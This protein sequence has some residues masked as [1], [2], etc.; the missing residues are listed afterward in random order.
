MAVYTINPI[1]DKRWYRFISEN[2][3]ATIF[4][5]PA[6][7]TVLKKQYG[8]S[9][10][11]LAVI[12]GNDEI[13]AGIPFCAVS[14]LFK[15]KWISLPFSDYSLPLF[16][17][18]EQL[19]EISVFLINEHQKGKVD[20]IEVY[21]E[22]NQSNGFAKDSSYVYHITE[23]NKDEK[24]LFNSFHR[25]KCQGISKSIKQNLNTRFSLEPEA[26]EIFY[27]LHLK[28]RKKLGIPIQPK[29]FFFHIYEHILKND[30]GFI[31]VVTKDNINLAAGLFMGFND[32][33]TYKY[34][35]SDPD[36]LQ[37][38]PNNLIIWSAMC[39]GMKKGFKFFDFGKSDLANEGLRSFKDGWSAVERPLYYSYLP[40]LPSSNNSFDFIKDKLVA[41]VIKSSPGI[42]CRLIGE[43]AYKYFPSI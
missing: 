32:T 36:H 13:T 8:F 18:E 17:H 35:A 43:V 7:L 21:W 28:T 20:S 38:R 41:P 26:V 39:E 12:N 5:H 1:E 37:Y 2:P 23:L 3:K 15:K 19:N 24:G 29:S 16:C 42:V 33:L 22:I 30:L 27:D 25:T 9:V 34:N 40:A 31:V 4:H 6:W 11:A 14:G 10:F